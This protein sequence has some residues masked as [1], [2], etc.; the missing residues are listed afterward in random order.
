MLPILFFLK[1]CAAFDFAN[2]NECAKLSTFTLRERIF[3][4]SAG[5]CYFACSFGFTKSNFVHSVRKQL[6][7]IQVRKSELSSCG[8]LRPSKA[9]VKRAHEDKMTFSL[10]YRTLFFYTTCEKLNLGHIFL[11]QHVRNQALHTE[12]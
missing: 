4:T 1:S 5:M 6:C 10:V 3:H 8:R 11:L 12:C 9:R 2:L 7:S